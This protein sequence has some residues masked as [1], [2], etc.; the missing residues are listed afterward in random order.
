MPKP[1]K[2]DAAIEQQAIAFAQWL[3]KLRGGLSHKHSQEYWRFLT[4]TELRGLV[5]AD[6]ER[7]LQGIKDAFKEQGEVSVFF[8]PEEPTPW[9]EKLAA[10]LITEAS[11]AMR[12]PTK[13]CTR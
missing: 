6:G 7:F 3:I 11:K 4:K 9:N 1:R 12:M 13:C 8:L 2:L 10:E 5:E